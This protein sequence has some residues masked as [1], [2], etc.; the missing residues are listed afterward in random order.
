MFV[1]LWLDELNTLIRIPISRN[2]K[3]YQKSIRLVL[4]FIIVFY[5]GILYY[6]RYYMTSDIE[7]ME[8]ARTNRFYDDMIQVKSIQ[9]S[10]DWI[11]DEI[12]CQRLINTVNLY[13]NN[14]K[15]S[16]P[17]KANK[18]NYSS[19][20]CSIYFTYL[21]KTYIIRFIWL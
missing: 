14:E 13:D 1:V 6:Y 18:H 2:S 16:A 20:I 11:M 7:Y 3:Q 4:K 10:R 21:Y 19:R 17:T 5:L 8:Q 15:L 9:T 12:G